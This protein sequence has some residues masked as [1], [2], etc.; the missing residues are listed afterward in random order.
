VDYR[1]VILK[2]IT[3]MD[4]GTFCDMQIHIAFKMNSSGQPIASWNEHL[5]ATGLVTGD[6]GFMD[7]LGALVLFIIFPLALNGSVVTDIEYPVR[8]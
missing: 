5:T 4:N 7:R 1:Q 8:K 3:E 6:Y 2:I